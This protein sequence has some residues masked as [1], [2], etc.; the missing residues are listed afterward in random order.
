MATA[1]ISHADCLKHETPRGHPE[2]VARLETIMSRLDDPAFSDLA[3]VEAPECAVEHILRVHP[4]S[5]FDKISAASPL[6]GTVN[7]DPD[8]HMS[9]GSFRAAMRAAGAGVKAV[10]LVLNGEFKNAFCATRPPGHH[11]ETARSMGFC[12]FGNVAIAAKYALDAAGLERVAVVDFDVHHGNGTSDLLWSESRALFASTHQMPL[13]PGSGHKSETGKH[14]QIIN[15]P[16][17]PGSGGRE[18]RRAMEV[19]ILPRIE[20]HDPELVLI[21]AGFDAHRRDP[22]ANLEFDESDFAWVTGALCD[23]AEKTCGG[24]IVSFLE[25]GYDLQALADSVAAHIE[26]L[27]G[28]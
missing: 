23:V 19:E 5:Y 12:L 1:L 6:G 13:Y 24:K 18:F 22:L 16:L 28:R 8:T 21:S 25:G 17:A 7:L 26:V 9:T 27:M 10:D 15:A 20:A 3:R 11:A 4:K 14:G 2:R